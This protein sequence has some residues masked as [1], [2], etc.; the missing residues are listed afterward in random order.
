MLSLL[1]GEPKSFN[2]DALL[3]RM[4]S[5]FIA[6]KK[7]EQDPY[8]QQQTISLNYMDVAGV[9]L[10]LH[11]IPTT[12]L[13]EAVDRIKAKVPLFLQSLI[14]IGRVQLSLGGNNEHIFNV[15]KLFEPDNTLIVDSKMVHEESTYVPTEY[16]LAVYGNINIIVDNNQGAPIGITV[17][18]NTTV[19]DVLKEAKFQIQQQYR[20]YILELK[21][22][23]PYESEKQT[24]MGSNLWSKS[25]DCT[26]VS[27]TKIKQSTAMQIYVKTLTGKTITLDVES[28]DSIEQIKIKIRDKEG[29]EPELQRLLWNVIQLEDKRTLEDYNIQMESTFHLCLRLRAGMMHLSS[30]RE[31]YQEIG[32][33]NS[34]L[35]SSIE[36]AQKI[37]KLNVPSNTTEWTAKR[38]LDTLLELKRG[39]I[40]VRRHVACTYL[41]GK[42]SKTGKTWIDET[43]TS[44]SSPVVA[45][46]RGHA[47]RSSVHKR[48]T[49]KT[50]LNSE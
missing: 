37:M 20:N 25:I 44:I 26:I 35:A 3:D 7:L 49:K 15:C 48:S 23:G 34:S 38:K 8:I 1:P 30:G 13:A 32:E 45:N 50:K 4:Q 5:I 12:T 18:G 10:Q 27:F 28:S 2:Y 33:S 43:I 21:F 6:I 47:V 19:K 39:Y 31:D 9:L 42:H 40:Q 41:I 46:K 24:V 17:H 16:A 14:Q 29:I 22:T 11:A 36:L